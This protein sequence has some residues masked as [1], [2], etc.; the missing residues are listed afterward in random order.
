MNLVVEIARD[1]PTGIEHG[2]RSFWHSSGTGQLSNERKDQMG[3]RVQAFDRAMIRC[4]VQ[5]RLDRDLLAGPVSGVAATMSAIEVVKDGVPCL[6]IVFLICKTTN[7]PETMRS[8]TD[9][10]FLAS[11]HHEPVPSQVTAAGSCAQVTRPG[12]TPRGTPN[13]ERGSNKEDRR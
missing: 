4:V 1:E 7:G 6:G 10:L 13:G 8:I 3:R 11:A 9:W 12:T 5:V 2:N